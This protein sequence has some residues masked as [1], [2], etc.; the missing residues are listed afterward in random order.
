LNERV[1]AVAEKEV[2]LEVDLPFQR[3]IFYSIDEVEEWAKKEIDFWAWPQNFDQQIRSQ[4]NLDGIIRSLISPINQIL[5]TVNELKRTHDEKN[6]NNLISNLS[7]IISEAYSRYNPGQPRKPELL[8]SSQPRAQFIQSL[9]KSNPIRAASVAAFFMRAYG[10]EIS[11]PYILDGAV[12]GILF[13]HG[14]KGSC[15]AET[16]SLE[17]LRSAWN[18]ELLKVQQINENNAETARIWKDQTENDRTKQYTEFNEFI[19]KNQLDVENFQKRISAEIALKG[20]VTYWQEKEAKHISKSRAFGISSILA[21]VCTGLYIGLIIHYF[22]PNLTLNEIT[23][24][25]IGLLVVGA[26]IGVWFI[27]VL[28]RNYLSHVH[29]SHDAEERIAMMK[30]Y[31]ALL[32]EGKLEDKHRNLILQAL[33]RPASTGIVKDDAA[34]PFMAEWLK[35]TTGTDA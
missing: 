27:R 2:F 9:I 18:E 6:R 20:P 4:L 21:F 29:L 26:T 8:H 1:L 31:L 19:K 28:V 11:N 23:L 17:K 12:S 7:R 34:P 5:S 15:E 3:V 14:F 24:R 13:D 25:H 35:R 32:E 16:A 33:F 22:A 30:T 10:V